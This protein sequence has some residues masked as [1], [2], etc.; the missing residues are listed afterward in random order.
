MVETF[1]LNRNVQQG[2]STKNVSSP[3]VTA[4]STIGSQAAAVLH[5]TRRPLNFENRAREVVNHDK[6]WTR[7]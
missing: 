1:P 5:F 4:E 3:E 2:F 6:K 7:Q